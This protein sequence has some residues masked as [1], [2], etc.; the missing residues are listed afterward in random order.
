MLRRRRGTG[1]I[2]AYNETAMFLGYILRAGELEKDCLQGRIER[3]RA[4]GR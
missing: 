3:S 1:F 2:E 4:R